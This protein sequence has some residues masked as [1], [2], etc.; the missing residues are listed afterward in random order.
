[1][2]K[3]I[4][5]N[6]PDWGKADPVFL[7]PSEVWNQRFFFEN[8]IFALEIKSFPLL[9][10]TWSQGFKKQARPPPAVTLKSL[11]VI[12]EQDPHSGEGKRQKLSPDKRRRRSRGKTQH[13]KN[14]GQTHVHQPNNKNEIQTFCCRGLSGTRQPTLGPGCLQMHLAPDLRTLLLKLK[15]TGSKKWGPFSLMFPEKI[16]ELFALL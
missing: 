6:K 7:A 1:M 2:L 12:R 8:L 10:F 14:P 5:I 3:K 4:A 11:W 15:R 9:V 16:L 13:I